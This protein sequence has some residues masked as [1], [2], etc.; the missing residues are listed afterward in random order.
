M[1]LSSRIVLPFFEISEENKTHNS[2]SLSQ[3]TFKKYMISCLTLKLLLRNTSVNWSDFSFSSFASLLCSSFPIRTLS[4]PPLPFCNWICRFFLLDARSLRKYLVSIVVMACSLKAGLSVSGSTDLSSKT[5]GLLRCCSSTSCLQFTESH[6]K[7]Y[8]GKPVTKSPSKFSIHAESSV[9]VGRSLR[10][11]EKT[12]KPNM[13]EIH[14]AQEL[15]DSL[16]N[17]GDKL[18]IVHFYSPGCGGC[19]ALHPKIC[20]LA[21]SN[22]NAAFL[23]VNFEDLKRMCHCL[24]IHVLPFFRF[25]RGAEGRLCSFSCTNSTI[26]KFKDSLIKH[27]TDRCSLGPPRG[28]DES[29][30]LSLASIGEIVTEKGSFKD[31][32]GI[33]EMGCE[34]RLLES[35]Q[36]Y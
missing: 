14:S 30:L 11:W 16:R 13:I 15:I 21:E 7:E 12:L 26:K 29:E 19:K 33:N 35:N 23:G 3:I 22:P 10:W 4:P 5:R 20:Q 27:G 1:F 36:A 6:S 25:Y 34:K 9:F 2:L 24:H 18:M 28:L 17:A 31:E 32:G 8:L